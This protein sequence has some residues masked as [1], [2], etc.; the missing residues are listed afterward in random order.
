MRRAKP[1]GG[2]DMRLKRFIEKGV[3]HQ[4]LDKRFGA[5]ED[6]EED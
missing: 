1:R 3:A 4:A 5:D 2:L 6:Q